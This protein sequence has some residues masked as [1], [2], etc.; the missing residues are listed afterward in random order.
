MTDQ[1]KNLIIP[2]AIPF[3]SMKGSDLEECVYWLLDA[4]GAK[5]LEWRSGGV[6][7]GAADGGR[8]LEA[9][10]YAPSADGE[11]DT[12]K[13]WI[14]CKG[15]KGTVEPDAVKQAV[16]NTQS[17]SDIDVLV[18]VTNAQFSN[19]TK[20]WLREWQGNHPR[21]KVK[22]WERSHLERFLSR[23]PDVVLRLYS[24][25]L[26][27]EGRFKAME[28]RF[29]NKLEFENTGTLSELWKKRE[30]FN[31]TAMGLFAAIVNEFAHGSISLRP[32]G[33]LLDKEN[34]LS[35]LQLGLLNLGYL[36]IR[37]NKV[38]TEQLPLF[39]AFA[40]LILR[41]LEYHSGKGIAEF[42]V[43]AINRDHSEPMPESVKEYLLLPIVNQLQS[44]MQDVCSSQCERIM[45]LDRSALLEPT[46]EISDYWRR[47]DPA[48]GIE[49]EEERRLVRL[50]KHDAKCVVGFSLDKEHSCQLFEI[51]PKLDA[52]SDLF[53]VIKR[54]SAFRRAEYAIKQVPK[55]NT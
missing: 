46:D 22:L 48:G 41:A 21:P 27:F 3:E 4:M 37:A 36:A 6:G 47:F 43:K 39:R 13:W 12:Q 23:H 14:E 33:T 51:D 17:R 28:D 25:A 11:M 15:R 45:A 50:E 34:V 18:V 16:V 26:S 7:G 30:E 44:E 35:V 32:W 29:W 10:F 19:P 53:E 24:E 38:G 55:T 42:L 52:I 9:T 2:S 54:V 31:F 8:D 5:D 40:Y 49:P 20:D 1:I